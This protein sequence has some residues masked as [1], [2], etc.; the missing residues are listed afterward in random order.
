M[1]VR[2]ARGRRLRVRYRHACRADRLSSVEGK[3][4]MVSRGRRQV[5]ARDWKKSHV[6]ADG[7]V[8]LRIIRVAMSS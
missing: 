2:V 7:R 4:P 3:K 6:V 5:F 1:D 8:R